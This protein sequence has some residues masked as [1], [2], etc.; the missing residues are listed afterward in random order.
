M[1]HTTTSVKDVLKHRGRDYG[2]YSTGVEQRAVIMDALNTLHKGTHRNKPLPEDIRVIF[3]DII[4]KMMRLSCNPEHVDSWI[5]LC[6]YATL[7]KEMKV[8]K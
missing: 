2:K 6:G 8:G 1:Q 4:L 7:A 3:S 5:D